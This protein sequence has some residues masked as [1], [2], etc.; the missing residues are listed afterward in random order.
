MYP[1]LQPLKILETV[2]EHRQVLNTSEGKKTL[3]MICMFHPINQLNWNLIQN[4]KGHEISRDI[5][6]QFHSEQ[7]KSF[8]NL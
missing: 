3:S 1:W 6:G 7:Q 5:I 8:R 2:Q 4:S